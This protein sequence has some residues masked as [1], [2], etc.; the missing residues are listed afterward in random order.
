[1]RIV[2]NAMHLSDRRTGLG[3]FSASLLDE[4][5]K[6]D[7]E[8][9][10]LV[11]YGSA[12]VSSL[13]GIRDLTPEQIQFA[14]A[15]SSFSR[16]LRTL[17]HRWFPPRFLVQHV[18]PDIYH[19]MNYVPV[20]KGD[21]TITTIYDMSFRICP[22]RL[23]KKRVI[24]L[25]MNARRMKAVD[26]VLTISRS[27]SSDIQDLLGVPEDRITIAYPGVNPIFRSA[28]HSRNRPIIINGISLQK[29]FVLYVGTIEPRKN[30][31]L[32]I[33]AFRLVRQE[34][35]GELTLV[36]AGGKGW[37]YRSLF[38]LT[39]QLELANSVKWM[40]YVRD[41]DLPTLYQSASVFCYPSHYEGFG[42]P[43]VEAMACGCPVVTSN[44][45]SL[46][47]IVGDAAITVDPSDVE[48]LAHAL[49][50]VLSDSEIGLKLRFQ[51]LQQASRFTW[52]STAE[53][54]LCMYRKVHVS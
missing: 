3:V 53:Q 22:E 26:H 54:V 8:N 49:C 14:G 24:W 10:Y 52:S 15:F 30:I 18:R 38:S 42:M 21:R 40:G 6:I 37:L 33:R 50:R 13:K 39:E 5:S 23:P 29:P 48:E 16:H 36:L 20:L 11:L 47:E 51:G 46:R 17:R 32:L 41:E 4:L 9:E 35:S 43:V 19:E 7:V 27:A 25:E 31:D 12:M 34:L 44:R 2:V 45:P 1:M 28:E